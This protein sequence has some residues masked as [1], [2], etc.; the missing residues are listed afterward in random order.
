MVNQPRHTENLSDEQ[1][2]ELLEDYPED[3]IE[4]YRPSLWV[5]AHLA[6]QGLTDN[7]TGLTLDWSL[8]EQVLRSL[9]MKIVDYKKAI[10][11]LGLLKTVCETSEDTTKAPRYF[12]HLT[13]QEFFA[14][15]YLVW[16]LAEYGQAT[17]KD[18][19]QALNFLK[20]EKYT[21]RYQVIFWFAAG[22]VRH[23]TWFNNDD[24]IQQ[25]ALTNLWDKGFLSEPQDITGLGQFH[26]LAHAF[27]EGG[28]PTSLSTSSQDNPI[29]TAWTFIK[30]T[31]NKTLNDKISDTK[32]SRLL[33][34]LFAT[35]TVCP[36]LSN[37]HA[38]ILVEDLQ[39]EDWNVRSSALY[40]L[41]Q[42]NVTDPHILQRI[43]E[44]LTD[45]VSDVRNNALY[46]LAQ[47]NVTDTHILQRIAER[48]T[49]DEWYIRRSTI[50]TLA[51]LNGTDPHILQRITERLT[52]D[53]EYV[54]Q[55]AINALAQLNVT[56][57]HILQRIAQ[58]LTDDDEDVRDSAIHA[59][60][61]LNV[62][63][64]HTLQRIAERLT[65]D[66][67][68]V[69]DSAIDA[70]AQLNVTDPHI[71]QRI[72]EYL[73]HDDWN[74]HQSAI[75]AL[76]RLRVTDAHIL[77]RIIERLTDDKWNVRKSATDALAQLN[78]TDPH[79]LQH[80]AER[81][82][83]DDW[84]V[85]KSAINA[86][87]QLN[88]TD[89]HILQRIAEYLKHKKK[90]VRTS[91]IN[92]LA[93]LN[94]TDPHILQRIIERLTDDKWNLRK[95][96][97]DALAQLNVTDIHIL[98]RIAERLTDD[99]WRVR[100]SAI[101]A[102]AQLQVTDSHILQRIAERLADDD[103]FIRDSAIN[104]LAQLNVTDPHILQRIAERLT[105]DYKHVRKSAIKAL[106]KL[107]VT[108]PHI[109][110]RIAE[111]LT[112]DK[113]RVRKSA[114]D[115]L[116][117]LNLTDPHIL[118]RIAERLTDDNE[119]VR[120][121]AIKVLAQLHVTDLHTIQRIA[122]R[123]TDDDWFVRDSAI[124]ALAKLNVT[125]AHILQLIADYLQHENPKVR[126]SAIKALAKLHV[127][128]IH[129][130]QRIAERLTDDEVDV[131]KSAVETLNCLQ[132][133]LT[134]KCWLPLWDK[135][136]TN[137]SKGA[138]SAI[139]AHHLMV[140]WIDKHFSTQTNCYLASNASL[141]KISR[142]FAKWIFNW[143]QL[144]LLIDENQHTLNMITNESADKL[145]IP[146]PHHPLGQTA[147]K[148]CQQ[149]LKL[150]S[151]IHPTI[152][153]P[154]HT[155]HL[156]PEHRFNALQ[157]HLEHYLTTNED[158]DFDY[159][160]QNILY[161]YA[162]LFE[163][164]PELWQDIINLVLKHPANHL[165]T[166]NPILHHIYKTTPMQTLMKARSKSVFDLIFKY[167]YRNIAQLD[168]AIQHYEQA[169]MADSNYS[170]SHHNLA[171]LYLTKAYSVSADEAPQYCELAKY[172]FNQTLKLNPTPELYAK[173]GQ[174]LY[175]QQR[176]EKALPLLTQAI[177]TTPSVT[178]INL[179]YHSL[180]L[181]T[182]DTTLQTWLKNHGKLKVN[183]AQLAYYLK[184][185]CYE[186]L[187]QTQ[188][189]AAWLNQWAEW[190]N[191]SSNKDSESWSD[192]SSDSSGE[193][194]F[195]ISQNLLITCQNEQ[196]AT[197][198]HTSVHSNTNKTNDESPTHSQT[199]LLENQPSKTEESLTKTQP[200]LQKTTAT[201]SAEADNYQ[202]RKA[203]GPS[204][205]LF[206]HPV[207]SL[208]TH[209]LTSTST[210]SLALTTPSHNTT[211]D[212]EG[213]TTQNADTLNSAP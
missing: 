194:K 82:T 154:E 146:F 139:T 53:N 167:E 6:F 163:Q 72:A 178:K 78:V 49:D 134:M 59:L 27:E 107:N 140:A 64:P 39:H 160:L 125:D 202:H 81:L 120:E 41:A 121:S 3:I 24:T 83:D 40:A 144:P 54:R 112:D 34:P 168:K 205:I 5:L 84:Y 191:T 164:K 143:L 8:Q 26:L 93:E 77:Q 114:I 19:K 170:E 181:P 185:R 1:K 21:P 70:L 47:L 105:D 63:D 2:E 113:W 149:A 11:P 203:S 171:S 123:L 200:A 212:N 74:V 17:S 136:L 108:D 46:A 86:L 44:R 56:D 43:V 62:T 132:A 91:A 129:I 55:S 104:A 138:L 92:A 36:H 172:S 148:Q 196:A 206:K 76:V 197:P 211:L 22:L 190:L 69:R 87:A 195:S 179:S 13:F 115:V 174:F 198:I 23:A 7:N 131:R 157:Q 85:R 75:D 209:P 111:R 79:I 37:N 180:E 51:Q 106:A 99:K 110:Q 119:Y 142:L 103:W 100:R 118:Q 15:L 182:L 66:N 94:V 101:N 73:K 10:L 161:T 65:D 89:I 35:L 30:D 177:K 98:Q 130:L 141:L 135:R 60:A 173:Y 20:N 192:S 210:T 169:V 32:N 71:L 45:D 147:F 50:N 9:Q 117:Q 162:S 156:K 133:H 52:D 207:N 42:L 189:Q 150:E 57:T 188:Q 48:L 88:V 116:V 122:E 176:Y 186:A 155:Q 128:D 18:R 193:D 90:K 95:S 12:M 102:L 67:E 16:S 184:Y 28:E 97:T 158:F 183:S 127:T 4:R 68:Y 204:D 187:G 80:I 124:N 14:A 25:T 208:N 29:N 61:Q 165:F 159:V 201:S 175:I 109:L 38:Q 137:H 199:Q 145:T 96:A 33:E 58:R 126:K 151:L 153:F 213:N 166:K 31:I 152:P